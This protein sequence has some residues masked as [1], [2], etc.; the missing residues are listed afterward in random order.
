[1]SV[2]Q[3]VVNKG[4]SA[5]AWGS[6][7]TF[8]RILMQLGSQIILARMLGPDLFGLFATALIAL[9]LVNFLADFGIA[10]SLIQK[11][12]V[13]HEDIRFVAT[14][15]FILGSLACMGLLLS[16]SFFANFFQNESLTPVIQCLAVV[17]LI[18]ALSAVSSN[19]LKRDIDFKKIQ[20]AS[21]L[22]YAI[23][24]LVI[25]I[26]LASHDAGIWALIAAFTSTALINL[27]LL[28]GA[29]RHPIRPL[30]W[31]TD[32][33]KMLEY[34]TTVL[35]TNITNWFV[36]S[37]DR[38]IIG[39]FFPTASVGYYTTAFNFVYN[40]CTTLIGVLQPALFST[41]ARI[42]GQRKE[43][44]IA[45][46][47]A[48]A[49][50][51]LFI[52]PIFIGIAVVSPTLVNALYGSAWDSLAPLMRPLAL[53][54]P[55]VVLIGMST[56]MLWIGGKIRHEFILQ[57]PVALLVVL[58]C[59]WASKFSTQHV[60]WTVF[61]IF[62]IR[63]LTIMGFAARSLGLTMSDLA[64]SLAGGGVVCMGT[65]LSLFIFD[66][67]C[68]HF[69][70]AAP[71]SLM[72]D[73]VGTAFSLYLLILIL[74]RLIHGSLG[75]LLARMLPRAGLPGRLLARRMLETGVQP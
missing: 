17:S 56:P 44:R 40:P 21:T 52:A 6:I 25:G 62:F 55:L 33:G 37:I 48:W 51:G 22:S 18:N 43:L 61:V 46:V 31:T 8:A 73:I 71:L 27:A 19:L 50:T 34:G 38:V 39:R 1:M 54:M 11:A 16:A 12:N 24:Y 59:L 70:L 5:V 32:A 36:S 15:Q 3:G 68:R 28:Y 60:A 2:S 49:A 10:Y 23:G 29:T 47:G 26:L 67:I 4:L 57:I 65:A 30:L 66:A 9:T 63:A 45:L 72:F 35:L 64:G 7:G 53:A 20:L 58:G 13:S 14:W 41:G 75:P 42:Q 69:S 74:P